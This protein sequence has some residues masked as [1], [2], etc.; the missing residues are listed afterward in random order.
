MIVKESVKGTNS[1]QIDTQ[2]QDHSSTFKDYACFIH[3][4][5]AILKF[6]WKCEEKKRES[7]GICLSVSAQDFLGRPGGSCRGTDTRISG[8]EREPRHKPHECA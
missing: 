6:I 4:G 8:T 7:G 1:L 5:K 2:A 3:I